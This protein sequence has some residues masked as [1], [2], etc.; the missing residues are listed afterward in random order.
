MA[1]NFN[2]GGL[3][4]DAGIVLDS[5]DKDDQLLRERVKLLAQYLGGTLGKVSANARELNATLSDPRAT[6]AY[7]KLLDALGKAGVTGKQATSAIVTGLSDVVS[8]VDVTAKE[9]DKISA[10]LKN[11]KLPNIDA[12]FKGQAD[13]ITTL[14]KALDEGLISP[15]TY[16]KALSRYKTFLSDFDKL[17]SG[18]PNKLDGSLE[19]LQA[20]TSKAL[21]GFK[22]GAIDLSP[23][24]QLKSHTDNINNLSK[25]LDAGLISQN[26]YNAALREYAKV[27][28]EYA[29]YEA[30][31]PNLLDGT[32]HAIERQRKESEKNAAV[33]RQQQ[34]DAAYRQRQQGRELTYVGLRGLAVAGGAAA[35][36][37]EALQSQAVIARA[38]QSIDQDL[39]NFSKNLAFKSPFDFESIINLTRYVKAL[40]FEGNQIPRILKGGVD[41]AAAL[42]KN[43]SGVE[44]LVKA[45]SDVKTKGYLAGEEIRQFTNSNIPVVQILADKLGISTSQVLERVKK[46]QI[47]AQTVITSTL[48]YIEHKYGGTAEK[49]ADIPA[50]KLEKL[51]DRM[52]FILAELAD[53]GQ[54]GVDNL[55]KALTG[56]V[57]GIEKLVEKFQGL[58]SSQK[59][60]I[61]TGVVGGIGALGAGSGLLFAAGQIT[62]IAANLQLLKLNTP[63]LT[64]LIESFKDPSGPVFLGLLKNVHKTLTDL[65]ANKWTISV[66]MLLTGLRLQSTFQEQ[67][68]KFNNKQGQNRGESPGFTE[69]RLRMFRDLDIPGFPGT[70]KDINTLNEMLQ[71]IQTEN[72]LRGPSV[73]DIQNLFKGTDLRTKKTPTDFDQKAYDK[74][75]RETFRNLGIKDFDLEIREFDEAFNKLGKFDINLKHTQQSVYEFALNYRKLLDEAFK[76]TGHDF[77]E[78]GNKFAR[79][80]DLLRKLTFTEVT[81]LGFKRITTF[82]QDPTKFIDRLPSPDN[83][84][85]TLGEFKTAVVDQAVLDSTSK[86]LE[87]LSKWGEATDHFNDDLA[88][89]LNTLTQIKINTALNSVNDSIYKI[90][91]QPHATDPA[92]TVKFRPQNIADSVNI[93]ID[94]L[95]KLSAA[96]GAFNIE[97][98]VEPLQ[99]LTKEFPVLVQAYKDGQISFKAY[100]QAVKELAEAQFNSTGKVEPT[101]KRQL[102]Y[103]R[104]HETKVRALTG[105]WK[106]FGRQV[107]TILTD[108]SRNL[109]NI[110][111]PKFWE[112]KE[113]TF[114]LNDQFRQMLQSGLE[115]LAVKGYADPLAAIKKSLIDIKNAATITDANKIAIKIFGEQGPIMAKAIREGTVSLDQLN[116]AL[117]HNSEQLKGQEE[118]TKK[119]SKAL[120][121]LGETLNSIARAG[122]ESAAKAIAKSLIPQLKELLH[123]I[124]DLLSKLPVVGGL[125]GK[126][127]GTTPSVGGS[128]PI[129]TGGGTDVSK[130]PLPIPGTPGN[131][132]PTLPGPPTGGVPG[133][134]GGGAGSVAGGA[135][136]IVNAVTGVVTAISSVVGNSQMAKMETTLNAI[137]ESMRYT[138][139]YALQIITELQTWLP[140]VH[141]IYMYLQ[142][143]ATPLLK[144]IRDAAKGFVGVKIDLAPTDSQKEQLIQGL[145]DSIKNV[146]STPGDRLLDTNSLLRQIKETLGRKL[147]SVKQSI[148]A[149]FNVIIPLIHD[150]KPSLL[151]KILGGIGSGVG[152]LGGIGGA[153]GSTGGGVIS[154]IVNP[155]GSLISG[156]GKLFGLG[157]DK[158]ADVA[159]SHS[160]QEV[161]ILRE[162][163]YPELTHQSDLF[164]GLLGDI[165]NLLGVE[166][167][168]AIDAVDNKLERLLNLIEN[169]GALTVSTNQISTIQIEN[170]DGLI[171]N[172]GGLNTGIGKLT[173]TLGGLIIKLDQGNVVQTTPSGSVVVQEPIN[174]TQESLRKATSLSNVLTQVINHNDSSQKIINQNDFGTSGLELTNGYLASINAQIY[175]IRQNFDINRLIDSQESMMKSISTQPK[176]AD[177]GG[178]GGDTYNIYFEGNKVDATDA[179]I[180]QL[181][182]KIQE[183]LRRRKLGGA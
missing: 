153:A 157:N 50:I 94:K 53:A 95:Q 115:G 156:I 31:L 97:D 181:A 10:A 83:T 134:P 118:Q 41:A 59:E 152:I 120:Q 123:H 154:G 175:D 70:T 67:L 133:V 76:K 86:I 56:G 167:H 131:T 122:I 71:H 25:A 17:K 158:D 51:K 29:K 126:V 57:T 155:I 8:K 21:S 151:Q 129:P 136:G 144:E 79:F 170:M 150:L 54:S 149:G 146:D 143:Y 103:V 72:K 171:S 169:K 62:Q 37:V 19:A 165:K 148:D 130:L 24:A 160:L 172:I 173:D 87:N 77:D 112:P 98:K 119:A 36:V 117:D 3:F 7:S 138:K 128:I 99:R 45:L 84:V 69:T 106:D 125:L 183:S 23:T 30:G 44:N 11:F 135:L 176:S 139:G 92:H 22:L 114:G 5:Y 63:I 73:A 40:N 28:Q 13:H 12:M 96:L 101:L 108:F 26:Q 168:N 1:D 179:E 61:S 147:D 132:P 46:K 93:D 102:E 81:P 80:Q 52:K 182:D 90:P 20:K 32:T 16:A 66:V 91:L 4:L 105:A 142:E 35:G 145:I 166:I 113:E 109:A 82:D 159:N 42:G 43:A 15:E 49:L 9:I 162:A 111:I 38:K 48:D 161:L 74:E 137:E 104:Q 18:L 33:T 78:E 110:I 100:A 121:L 58:T 88:R 27:T 55:V 60:L 65:A 6:E 107:S 163:I 39:F 68:D 141:E 140:D 174:T 2:I 116:K 14:K 85:S 47:D 180:R 177:V 75:R 34:L 124:G 127:F 178:S 164:G 64:S 89:V